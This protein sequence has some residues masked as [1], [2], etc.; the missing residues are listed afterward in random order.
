MNSLE[1]S[2]NVISGKVKLLY[3]ASKKYVR[4]QKETL[5]N[6]ATKYIR[7]YGVVPCSADKTCSEHS[8][9]TIFPF[10]DPF[11]SSKRPGPVVRVP[12]LLFPR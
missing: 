8:R 12:V 5:S 4:I 9:K 2:L 7:M 10:V 6:Y 11:S 1:S 3:S